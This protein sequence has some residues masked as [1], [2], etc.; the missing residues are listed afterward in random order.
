MNRIFSRA[1][2]VTLI[3]L[4]LVLCAV[5]YGR[6]LAG[7]DGSINVD[8]IPPYQ[9]TI[10]TCAMAA[11]S[12]PLGWIGLMPTHTGGPTVGDIVF[13][14]IALGANSLLVG[15]LCGRIFGQRS[16]PPA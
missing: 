10:H 2:I 15:Y 6:F 5:A 12:L 13:A 7:P 1:G 4:A 16:K 8:Q 14:C 3:H 9:L 11:V